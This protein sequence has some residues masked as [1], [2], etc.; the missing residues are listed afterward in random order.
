MNITEPKTTFREKRN[1]G[2]SSSSILHHLSRQFM[3]KR[4]V[5]V[6]EVAFRMDISVN[7][8]MGWIRSGDV[9]AVNIAPSGRRV[10]YRVFAPSV[11]AMFER[12]SV[13]S[14]KTREVSGCEDP[15]QK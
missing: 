11:I 13:S 6:S 10:L 15:Q 1:G 9:E 7:L 5:P 8:V 12:R 3:G 4:Y 2:K 14:S